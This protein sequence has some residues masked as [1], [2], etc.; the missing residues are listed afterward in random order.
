MEGRVSSC[1]ARRRGYR[2]MSASEIPARYLDGLTSR[3]S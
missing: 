1:G 3:Y 2:I